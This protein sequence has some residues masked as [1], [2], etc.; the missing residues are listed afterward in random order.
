MP[1]K[2]QQ[3]AKKPSWWALD[4]NYSGAVM[5]NGAVMYRHADG[6]YARVAHG[7]TCAACGCEHI[8]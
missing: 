2:Q 1:R 8:P 3:P 6:S 4:A 5:R 7:V